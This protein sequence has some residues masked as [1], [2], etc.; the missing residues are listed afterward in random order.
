LSGLPSAA[1]T[2]RPVTV[3]EAAVGSAGLLG[4]E[5]DV[6]ANIVKVAA[7]TAGARNV[8]PIDAFASEENDERDGGIILWNVHHAIC[9][10]R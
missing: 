8:R 3:H 5:A 6:C 7:R 4:P 9:P 2:T 1:V 10:G